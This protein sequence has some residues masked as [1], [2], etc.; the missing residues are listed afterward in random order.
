MA[1][2]IYPGS[3][4]PPT[5]GHVDVAERA[6][7]HFERVVIA[8]VTNPNK[9]PLFTSQEREELLKR[10]LSHLPKI[11]VV[12]FDGLTVELAKSK[13][14]DVIVKGLRAVSDLESELQMAQMNSNLSPEIDTLFVATNPKWGFIS[15]SLRREVARFGGNVGGLVPPAVNEALGKKFP[16]GGS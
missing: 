7:R 11:E 14:A 4:D 2:A 5:N 15:S 3:F 1:V 10:A 16:S 13:G 8:I 6:A 12:S 9:K